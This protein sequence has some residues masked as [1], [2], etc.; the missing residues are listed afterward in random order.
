MIGSLI[1]PTSSARVNP[2]LIGHLEKSGESKEQG[3]A[4]AQNVG[5]P[6]PTLSQKG[7]EKEIST[8]RLDLVVL[9]SP[10]LVAHNST[11]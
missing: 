5:P 8:T 7:Y 3:W 1:A 6:T 9:V 10:Y 2:G 4:K 11:A